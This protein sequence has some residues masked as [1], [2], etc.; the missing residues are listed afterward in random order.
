MISLNVD[1]AYFEQSEPTQQLKGELPAHAKR[2]SLGKVF[3]ILGL[4]PMISRHAVAVNV[5]LS[6]VWEVRFVMRNLGIEL[7]DVQSS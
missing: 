4:R 1:D 2:L 3:D 5:P 7:E 6:R